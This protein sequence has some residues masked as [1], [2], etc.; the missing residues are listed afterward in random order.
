MAADKQLLIDNINALDAAVKELRTTKELFIKAKGLD[1]QSEKMRA[2]AQKVKDDL[3]AEKKRYKTLLEGKNAAM[4][5]VTEAMTKRMSAVLPRGAAVVEIKED[6]TCFIGWN[7]GK[8]S[9]P[10]SGLSGGEKASFGPALCK[11]LGGTILL[12]EAAELDPERLF[13]ALRKYGEADIQVIVSS[14]HEP[15]KYPEGWK[16]VRLGGAA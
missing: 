1:E 5:N 7:N 4:K 8:T 15:D 14:C 13:A 6:G 16:P 2:E 10:Y 12:V 3:T 9:V 11:A